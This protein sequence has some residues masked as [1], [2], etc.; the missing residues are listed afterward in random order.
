MAPDNNQ[1]GPQLGSEVGGVSWKGQNWEL[2]VKQHLLEPLKDM[3]A[4]VERKKKS[5]INAFLSG[6]LI[7]HH[8]SIYDAIAA[9][10]ELHSWGSGWLLTPPPASQLFAQCGLYLSFNY[11]FYCCWTPPAPPDLQPSPSPTP[12]NSIKVTAVVAVSPGMESVKRALAW[13]K[14][15]RRTELAVGHSPLNRA[16]WARGCLYLKKDASQDSVRVSKAAS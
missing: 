4:K 9:L 1:Q 6:H 16:L 7:L 8:T 12:S 14:H 2:G 5:H 11:H 10:R 15:F 13:I 3:G